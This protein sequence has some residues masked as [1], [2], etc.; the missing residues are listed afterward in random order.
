MYAWAVDHRHECSR[1]GEIRENLREQ[2]RIVA[3]YEE[4]KYS[5]DD[6]TRASRIVAGLH[7]LLRFGAG[8]SILQEYS[9]NSTTEPHLTAA[10]SHQPPVLP[11]ERNA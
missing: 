5:R 6:H 10:R 11:F 1:P 3:D 7:N 9:S 2:T 8:K 4:W